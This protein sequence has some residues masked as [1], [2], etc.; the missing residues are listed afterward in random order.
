VK[1][2]SRWIAATALVV[3]SVLLMACGDDDTTTGATIEHKYG[4]TQ[5]PDDPQRVVTIGFTEQ[6][7]ALALGVQP[8]AVRE[9]LEGYDW[10]QR[11]WAQGELA[12]FEPEVI[13]AAEIDFESVAQAAPDL[14]I[15]VNSGMTEGEYKKLAEIAPTV[16]QTDEYPDFGM[17]WQEQTL[18]IGEALGRS[19][20]AEDL[21]ADVEGQIEQAKGDNPEL[22]SSSFVLGYVNGGDIGAYSSEDYRSQ[23]FAD[24]GL[25]PSKEIDELAGDSF[26][27]DFDDEQFR[28]LE[29]DVV[30]MYA[31]PED[32]QDTV[33][34]RLD[35]VNE[36]R[37]L[38]MDLEDDLAGALGFASP[39]S[40]PYF[41]EEAAPTLQ[42]AI[43]GG[44]QP[45]GEQTG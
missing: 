18:M 35:A 33:L 12:G 3:V 36:D 39:L 22:E 17:P 42:T 6:D 27:A 4:A 37:V 43:G 45:Q 38:Y 23:L 26:Y 44:V 1:N 24:L 19:D 31:T 14:I 5:V 34:S 7:T 16:A 8:V 9:F 28:L 29:Q 13:S 41:L 25:A 40:I 32:V 2:G 11:P 10:Q 20:E 30:A 15:G 21:V